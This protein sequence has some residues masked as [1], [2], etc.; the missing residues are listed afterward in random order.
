MCDQPTYVS[1]RVVLLSRGTTGHVTVD[2]HFTNL[3]V[4]REHIPVESEFNS[5]SL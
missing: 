3:E 4:N 2:E 1:C 5:A